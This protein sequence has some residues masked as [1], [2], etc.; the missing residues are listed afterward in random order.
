MSHL[1]AVESDC[2][3][4]TAAPKDTNESSGVENAAPAA[5]LDLKTDAVPFDDLVSDIAVR[6]RKQLFVLLEE[7][8]IVPKV[9]WH[10]VFFLKLV[11]CSRY[12]VD[13]LSRHTPLT[14]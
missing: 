4:S 8:G 6:E 7:L 10:K 2:T 14:S 13:T 12:N 11:F 3:A 9:H 5:Q 1:F